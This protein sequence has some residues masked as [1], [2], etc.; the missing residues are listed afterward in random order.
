LAH[1]LLSPAALN[2][3]TSKTRQQFVVQIRNLNYY[4]GQ[5]RLYAGVAQHQSGFAEGQISNC[6][7]PSGSG[8]TTL[9]LIGSLTVSHAG[10]LKVLERELGINNA[11]K[12]CGATLALSSRLIMFESLTASQT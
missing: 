7:G 5:G 2:G 9:S 11:S 8:K 4:Y 12:L 3:L 1:E 6:N 10:S